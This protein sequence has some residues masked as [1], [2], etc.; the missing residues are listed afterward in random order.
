MIEGSYL[1]ELLAAPF[2]ACVVLAGI[3]CYLGIHV[4]MREVIFVDLAMAQIAAL[5]AAVGLLAG[6]EAESQQA[7]CFSLAFTLLGAAIF[8]MGTPVALATKGTVRLARGLASNT[9]MTSSFR[10]N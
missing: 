6:F 2:V 9:Y 7:Y 4:L 8:A 1:L 3:H 10:A 5:G